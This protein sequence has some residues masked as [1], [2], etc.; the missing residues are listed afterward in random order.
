MADSLF[1]ATIVAENATWT[2]HPQAR[3]CFVE[4]IGGGPGR[5]GGGGGKTKPK[6]MHA[7]W[8]DGKCLFVPEAEYRLF[9]EGE[10]LARAISQPRD[11]DGPRLARLYGPEEK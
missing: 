7:V 10:S 1:G 6:W 11:C 5:H 4:V 2:K 9:L 8:R 3:S